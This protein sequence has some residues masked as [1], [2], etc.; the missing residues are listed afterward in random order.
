MSA[1][2][3]RALA[4]YDPAARTLLLA[5]DHAGIKPLYWLEHH[6]GVAFA[7]EY[8]QLLR[9]PW[10]A[11]LRRSR[12]AVEMYLRL[13]Y[14]PAPLALLE[15]T[16]MLEPG[17]W[18]RFRPDGRAVHGRYFSFTRQGAVAPGGRA[19][20]EAVDAAVE[21]AVRR[22]MVSDAPLGA[23]LSG[24]ID[25]PRVAA[26]MAE[27]GAEPVHTFSI[28]VDDRALDEREDAARYAALLRTRHHER[29][30]S[31]GAALGLLEDVLD[32]S[33]EPL[34]D[35]GMFPALAVSA[36][37]RERVTVALSGEGGDELFW[38]YVQRQSPALR[39]APASPGVPF[40]EGYLAW[41]AK[42][43]REQ[44][45]ACFPRTA[46]WPDHPFYRWDA[47]GTADRAHAMR[48][49]EWEAYL[50]F[51]LLKTDRASMFH[52]LEV[53]V[54]LLDRQVVDAARAL[55]P[56][57]CLDLSTGVGKLPLRRALERRVGWQ[58]PGKRGFTVPMG[59]WM[60]GPLRDGM[61]ESI[62]SLR[63]LDEVEVDRRALAGLFSRHLEGCED[64]GTALWRIFFLD[65]WTER[66]AA[67]RAA[68]LPGA[69]EAA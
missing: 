56:A 31:E 28:G 15:G 59:A 14:I 20:A 63:G 8:T 54:P 22:Q 50:P 48:L 1:R 2:S 52:S 67:T 27:G 47:E 39:S 34:A 17:C 30:V 25:S 61:A 32:A 21:G 12:E 7:S 68:P 6:E 44:F 40:G 64:N 51:I 26:C 35:E 46:W 19:A 13:G 9:H 49:T 42:F 58:S 60:R 57:D 10:S 3:S 62:R 55:D 23:F 24:G 5:R 4:F 36:L 38:G 45:R 53:R 69:S 65:R 18:V 29:T 43:G 16:R 33:C 37:A 41:F 11:G 66:H